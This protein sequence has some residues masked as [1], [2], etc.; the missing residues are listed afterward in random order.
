M[1]TRGYDL[2]FW[3]E[4]DTPDS[5]T[6]YEKPSPL[7]VA[8]YNENFRQDTQYVENRYKHNSM[9]HFQSFQGD[10]S[11]T[12]AKR[13]KVGTQPSTAEKE[14]VSP[15]NNNSTPNAYT[16]RNMHEAKCRTQYDSSPRLVGATPSTQLSVKKKRQ[17]HVHTRVQVDQNRSV[18]PF[19]CN[20]LPAAYE[21]RRPGMI[22][23]PLSNIYG[24]DCI[25]KEDLPFVSRTRGQTEHLST[26][27]SHFPTPPTDSLT[28]LPRTRAV[29]YQAPNI[30]ITPEVTA[31]ET[32]RG[33]FWVAIE[34]SATPRRTPE[35][36]IQPGARYERSDLFMDLAGLAQDEH[37]FE[38][39]PERNSLR[40]LNVQVLPTEQSSIIRIL[41]EQPFPLDRL[42]PGSS[43]FLL[44]KV[45]VHVA[46]GMQKSRQECPPQE[47]DDL[48][49]A[50]EDE[51]GDSTV[52]YMT[53]RLS[54]RLS[55]FPECHDMGGMSDE[56]LTMNSKIET[57]ATASVKVHNAMSLWSP[58]PIS[59][60]N[61]LIPLIERH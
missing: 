38:K 34:V 5:A 25:L 26:P 41:Q 14:N 15:I 11:L 45:R 3:A 29:S 2:P 6:I 22:R 10:G 51:L 50:L 16:S 19:S 21:M 8:G 9:K 30:N 4:L 43:I 32:G 48:I 12:V 61:P 23:P 31:I 52:S 40:D 59:E 53:V 35:R 39:S 46:R 57:V 54:H 13:R 58:A 18:S 17:A 55:A 7:R 33:T 49:E 47:I 44:V 24:R 36:N 28:T 1:T 27:E 37:E 20:T 56:S 60:S 42:D